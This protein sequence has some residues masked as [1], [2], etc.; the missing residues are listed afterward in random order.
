MNSEFPKDFIFFSDSEAESAWNDESECT[1]YACDIERSFF[2]KKI[3]T[4]IEM[5]HACFKDKYDIYINM[6]IPYLD[7]T[8]Y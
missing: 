8:Y 6:D 7:R 5:K 4:Y 2:L 1:Q 3:H